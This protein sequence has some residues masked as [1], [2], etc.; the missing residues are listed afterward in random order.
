[1]SCIT[2][3]NKQVSD[4]L[5]P[6]SKHCIYSFCSQFRSLLP[7]MGAISFAP[8]NESLNEADLIDLIT[9]KNGEVRKGREANIYEAKRSE[10]PLPSPLSDQAKFRQ[11]YY[12]YKQSLLN[13]T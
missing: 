2:S 1:M 3:M 5:I 7:Y 13:T 10:L 6:F 8:L 12:Q 11:S 4:L 9:P